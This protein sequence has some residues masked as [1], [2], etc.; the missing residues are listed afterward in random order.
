MTARYGSP[1]TELT[2][3]TSRANL[4]I[5]GEYTD[6]NNFVLSRSWF[7]F[8]TRLGPCAR[9]IGTGLFCFQVDEI[10]VD[11]GKEFPGQIQFALG[12]E[13][14]AINGD[15]SGW[16]DYS[17]NIWSHT[18]TVDSTGWGTLSIP[19]LTET[20]GAVLTTLDRAGHVYI[21]GLRQSEQDAGYTGRYKIYSSDNVT[22]AKRPF[23]V[24]TYERISGAWDMDPAPA[25]AHVVTIP[26][27]S[28]GVDGVAKVTGGASTVGASGGRIDGPPRPRWR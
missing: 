23:L 17:G 25:V 19:Y 9:W 3:Y 10:V 6:G 27:V 7:P 11:G 4:Y 15:T 16:G 22:P 21:R 26:A 28:T 18:L 5:G 2:R 12:T 20:Q 14:E 1:P 24:G 8:D 13:A